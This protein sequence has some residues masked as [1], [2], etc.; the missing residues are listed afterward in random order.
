[1]DTKKED[2]DVRTAP[3]A[4]AMPAPGE[5]RPGPSAV[6]S[7]P[8]HG[9][10]DVADDSVEGLQSA[11]RGLSV[12]EVD[13]HPVQRKREREKDAGEGMADEVVDQG[14]DQT[15]DPTFEGAPS[16]S[17][18][19]ASPSPTTTTLPTPDP[20]AAT[21]TPITNPPM[22][23]GTGFTGMPTYPA[24]G[25]N[26]RTA[27]FP[28]ATT[29]S[30][31]VAS[32]SEP[33]WYAANYHHPPP[34]TGA[35]VDVPRYATLSG[36]RRGPESCGS[37]S[38]GSGRSSNRSRTRSEINEVL[39]GA[40]SKIISDLTQEIRAKPEPLIPPQ[41]SPTMVGMSPH[42]VQANHLVAGLT[43]TLGSLRSRPM[44]TPAA[45][46]RSPFVP[47]TSQ[48]PY[49]HVGNSTRAELD[50]LGLTSLRAM[51]DV[52]PYGSSDLGADPSDDEPLSM[53]SASPSE[54]DDLEDPENPSG[55]KKK[56]KKKTRRPGERRSQ[57]AKAIATSKIVVTLPEFTG[58]DLSEFVEKFGRFLR[59][60]GQAY[61]SG[62]VKCDVL[63][64]CC[65]TKYL[66]KQV[67]QI[68]TKSATFADV[69]AALE[70]QYP[71]YETDLSIR[72]EIQNLA[73]LPNNPKPGRV[74]EMLA[75]LDH[76]AG[77]LTPGSYSSDDLLFW[78][79]AKLPGELW[80]ECRSTAERKTRVLHYEDLCVLL[81][82]LA[83]EKESD[84]HLNNYC[85]GGGGSGS[86][87]KG[88]QGCRPGQ[89]TTPKHACIMENVKEPFW[90]DA[91]DEQGHL[92]HAPDCEQR[93]CFV[94]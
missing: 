56:K 43:N 51:V 55:R 12:E 78:L 70:R 11:F 67:K 16:A 73:V 79:V 87:G 14:H 69:L 37:R 28:E 19:H 39:R 66:E 29:T 23:G 42:R 62:R 50:R 32:S 81:L 63:L 84:Q 89:G 86:Q 77:R 22:A 53:T 8:L 92:Q 48:P 91:R 85:P 90:C 33:R 25:V 88:Y 74:S 31:P 17:G 38:R 93:D 58:K 49:S 52:E 21:S 40:T 27:A 47:R 61:A 26:A 54:D 2:T 30:E 5:P 60:T 34:A 13:T 44:P 10:V 18:L 4:P 35:Y 9:P 82:E 68:S 15:N 46:P 65:K 83:P 1:M 71:T 75:D 20:A 7:V 6:P 36:L 76:W 72:A 59:L 24:Y 94:V 57:E 45:I 3:K 41:A 64:Q 80:D